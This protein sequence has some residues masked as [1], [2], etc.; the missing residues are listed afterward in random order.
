MESIQDPV[1]QFTYMASREN[2]S[3]I[4]TLRLREYSIKVKTDVP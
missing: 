2:M 1:L 4:Y 3:Q